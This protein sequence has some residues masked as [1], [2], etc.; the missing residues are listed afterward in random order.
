VQPAGGQ[1]RADGPEAQAE[2]QVEPGAGRGRADKTTLLDIK[3]RYV[4]MPEPLLA[5]GK[6]VVVTEFGMRTYRG[7]DRG[8]APGFGVGDMK[9]AAPHQLPFIGRFFREHLNGD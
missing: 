2:A 3:D 4:E 5:R 7:A 8:G 6:P 1:Q 9:R